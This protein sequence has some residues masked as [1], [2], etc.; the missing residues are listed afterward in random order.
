MS[1]AAAERRIPDLRADLSRALRITGVVIVPA[2]FLFLAQGPQ[3]ATL[4]FAHGAA[5]TAS[6]QPL[7]HMLQAFGPGLVP[8]SAQFLLLRGFYAFEDTRTPFFMA[9]LIAAVNIALTTVCHLLLPA[10]WA[11]TGMAAAYSLSY[12]AGLA[13]TVLLLRRKLGGR[14]GDGTLGRTYVKLLLCSGAAAGLGW[15]ATRALAATMGTGIWLTA[16]ALAAGTAATALGYFA[17]AR[18]MGVGELRG[19]PGLK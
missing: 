19:L 1:M 4:L 5:D 9:A 8:F 15:A 10:H 2:G 16:V 12:L 3:I 18:L 7:G 11:V 6:A 13:V 17:L 14:I